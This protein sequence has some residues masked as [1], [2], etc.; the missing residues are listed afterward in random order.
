MGK[1]QKGDLQVKKPVYEIHT[2]DQQEM[3]EANRQADSRLMDQQ[4]FLDQQDQERRTI[5]AEHQKLNIA[6][7]DHL[8]LSVNENL[9]PKF[10]KNSK[11]KKQGQQDN[12]EKLKT[13]PLEQ[14]HKL[15]IAQEIRP[16][17][18]EEVLLRREIFNDKAKKLH[19]E[20][21]SKLE[22]TIPTDRDHLVELRTNMMEE[23]A[24]YDKNNVKHGDYR[25]KEEVPQE[26]RDHYD[27]LMEYY[28][29]HDDSIEEYHSEGQVPVELPLNEYHVS[30]DGVDSIYEMQGRG[31]NNCFC[32]SGSAML[33][34]F[35]RNRN[36]EENPTRRFN[37]ND[38]RA[39]RP[40]IKKYDPAGK[41]IMN[42]AQRKDYIKEVDRYTGANKS[43]VGNVFD[44][45]DF[46]LDNLQGQNA[47]LNKMYFQMPPMKKGNKE[48]NLLRSN[49][50]KAVFMDKISEVLATGNV[51]SFLEVD[52]NYGHYLTITGLDGDKIQYL[53][54]GKGANA[55]KTQYKSVDEFLRRLDSAGNPIEIAWLSDMKSPEEL[56]KEYS[57]L[58][59]DAEKGY[60]L[61]QENAD[62]IQNVS[63]TKGIAV[64]KEM[65]DMG[66]GMDGIT[67]VAY[68]PNP[69]AE[70]ENESIEEALSGTHVVQKA[71]NKTENQVEQKPVEKEAEQKQVE[72]KNVQQPEEEQV[73]EKVEEQAKQRQVEHKQVEKEQ[74]EEQADQKTERKQ[75]EKKAVVID[76][77]KEREMNAVKEQLSG[78]HKDKNK[79]QKKAEKKLISN[80]EKKNK[81][82]EAFG[83]GFSLDK[84]NVTAADSEYMRRVKTALAEYLKIRREIFEKHGFE[85]DEASA[86]NISNY[87]KFI[88]KETAG[89][90]KLIHNKGMKKGIRGLNDSEREVLGN[91]FDIV[92]GAVDDYKFHHNKHLAFGRGRARYRQISRIKEQL[93]MDNARFYLSSGRRNIVNSLDK[94]Y[95]GN[96]T[97]RKALMPTWHKAF[98]LSSENDVDNQIYR[99]KRRRQKAEGTLPPWYKRAM[100]WTG[101]ATIN[102]I[103]RL[104][105]MYQG[106]GGLVDRSL[107][108]ATMLAANS[109]TFAGKIV[110]APLKL[111]SGVFNGASKYI[112]RSKKRWEVDYSLK[113]GWK[114]VDD[115]RR[116]FRKYLK[117]A[118]IL[119]AAVTETITRGIPYIFGHHFKSGVYKRTRKWSKAIY[120]DVKDVMKGIG[121]KNYGAEDRAD[122]DYEMAGGITADK[123]GNVVEHGMLNYSDDEYESETETAEEST[124]KKINQKK[125]EKQEE[126]QDQVKAKQQKSENRQKDSSSNKKAEAAQG[127]KKKQVSSADQK[128]DLNQAFENQQIDGYLNE[129]VQ[130][131]YD[132]EKKKVSAADQMLNLKKTEEDV[133]DISILLSNMKLGK[134]EIEE[135]EVKQA[136]LEAKQ[137]RKLSHL[138]LNDQKLTG[139]SEEMEKVKTTLEELELALT[140]EQ[141]HA[142]TDKNVD[143]LQVCYGRAIDACQVYCDTKHPKTDTGKRRKAKVQATLARLLS[144]S[145]MIEL[146]RMIIKRDGSEAKNV[147]N[148]LQLLSLTAVQDLAD[149][150]VVKSRKEK[151]QNEIDTINENIRDLKADI[152]IN[153]DAYMPIILPKKAAYE[154]E[155]SD[156]EKMKA[157]YD[158]LYAYKRDVEDIGYWKLT[159]G[160]DKEL[161]DAH[162]LLKEKEAE[163]DKAKKA[164]EEAASELRKL[165]EEKEALEKSVESKKTEYD[166][167]DKELKQRKDVE[168]AAAAQEKQENVKQLENKI[169]ELP[170][171]L[172][173]LTRMISN[174]TMPTS[175]IKN[176]NKV[177]SSERKALSDLLLVRETLNGFKVGTAHSKM[178]RIADKYVRLIQDEFGNAQIQYGTV[179]VPIAFNAAYTVDMIATDVMH[180]R[181]IYGDHAVYDVI[182]DLKTDLSGMTRGDLIRT[183]DFA[184]QIIFEITG[185]PKTLLN[186]F[187]ASELKSFALTSLET[188]N[189]KKTLESFKKNLLKTANTKN[190][191]KKGKNI[192][193]VLNQELQNV[194][195][196]ETEGIELN[197]DQREDQSNWDERERKVRDLVADM[198]FSKDTWVA[199]NLVKDPAERMRQML[200]DHAEAVAL[201]IAD[202]FRNKEK[203]PNGLIETIL[204]KLPL[205][206]M[207]QE[208]VKRFR[209][210]IAS[211]LD[212]IKTFMTDM[213]DEMEEGFMKN[214]A[215]SAIENSNMALLSPPV[216][217]PHIKDALKNLNKDGMDKLTDL[218]KRIDDAVK[219]SMEGVQES[220]EKCIGDIFEV[221]E[222]EEEQKEKEEKEKKAKNEVPEL[223]L[224]DLA[225]LLDG[226]TDEEFEQSIANEPPMKQAGKR[227]TRQENLKVYR[228]E[229][230]R[231]EKLEAERAAAKAKEEADNREKAQII[232][233]QKSIETL[234][235]ET[236]VIK[237]EVESMKLYTASVSSQLMD[238]PEQ[239]RKKQTEAVEST[240]IEIMAKEN[241]IKLNESELVSRKNV[242]AAYEKKKRMEAIQ[243]RIDDRA[244]A[245]KKLED[246]RKEKSDEY[247]RRFLN[248][249][250]DDLSI[251]AKHDKSSLK[252]AIDKIDEDLENMKKKSSKELEKILED[253]LKGGKKG[254]S[255]FIKNVFLT[256]FK[257]V[258]KLDKRSMVASAIKNS[259]ALPLMSEEERKKLTDG[260]ILEYMSSMIG[261][262]FKGA[263][264]L[265]QKML[266]GLPIASL[267]K[268]LR[269][270]V[271]DTQDSL[272]SIPDEVVKAHMD[273][274]K[275]RSAGKITKIE[276][277]KSLGAASVGQA[278]LCKVY[279]PD[280]TEGKNVVIKL[281][282]PDVR[283]RMMREKA[284][285][286]EAA[287]MTDEDGMLASEVAEKRKNNVV[288]G[289]EATYMGNLQRIEEELD[290]TI[291]AKN[292]MEGQVYDNPVYDK[293]AKKYKENISNS[294]KLSDL[295]EATSDT[296]VMEIAG[297][298]TVKRYMSDVNQRITD[299]LW[300][301]CEKVDEVD[302]HGQKTGKQ[303]LKRDEKDGS[304]VFRELNP[305]EKIALAPIIEEVSELLKDQE[306]R[307]KALSQV[308]EKW[309]TEGVFQKGY[310]HG[311]LHAGNIMIS[312][313]GVTVIDFGNATI[314]NKDQQKHI[315]RMMVAATQGDVERFRHGFHMLLENTPE[316]VYQEKRDELTL[317]FKEIMSI[318]DESSAAERI[319]VALV[320]AQE[321]G[322]EL[323]PTI[324]NFSSCQM[325]LQNTLNDMN[326]SLKATRANL[327][328][329]MKQNKYLPEQKM[330]D[331]VASLI[332][333][334]KP[335]SV[336]EQKTNVR[337]A[338]TSRGEIDE[339]AFREMLRDKT[340][341]DELREAN[342]LNHS[343]IN[344]LIRKDAKKFND[345]LSGKI[346]VT[347][348]FDEMKMD[349]YFPNLYEAQNM[350]KDPKQASFYSSI[351]NKATQMFYAD[352]AVKE[353]LKDMY[354][355]AT[356]FEEFVELIK[357][358]DKMH[359]N[360]TLYQEPSETEKRLDAF[361]KAQDNKKTTPQQLKQL[362]DAVWESYRAEKEKSN[363]AEA[364]KQQYFKTLKDKYFPHK[365]G[366]EDFIIMQKKYTGS[367]LDIL[368]RTIDS[369]A[370]NKTNG[371]QLKKV[372]EELF[373]LH[374]KAMENEESF[375]ANEAALNAKFDEMLNILWEA[376]TNAI[377]ELGE[378]AKDPIEISKRDP[379]N[380]LEI[381]GGIMGDKK[382][383]VMFSLDASVTTKMIWELAT[384]KVKHFFNANEDE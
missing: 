77:K 316:E 192:N 196:K 130:A 374:K 92:S 330:N 297:T 180:N 60:S 89:E 367:Q 52:G 237:N 62:S 55:Q 102:N 259:N 260:Q 308:V 45:G 215:K 49:N 158:K 105:M 245:F 91:A 310:Y 348:P 298:K 26:V 185:V 81:D 4:L 307:Q 195:H 181:K 132:M 25:W 47:M 125:E 152:V 39:Y 317:I 356:S 219:D 3:K 384:D 238:M 256:Y 359:E 378:N 266:Q 191:F 246:E 85:N 11:E 334:N 2:D 320:R 324:A 177:T 134:Y 265:F 140:T 311:D 344:E 351:K 87:N 154:M 194:G 70:A 57:N 290:L 34:Q 214:M 182:S 42:E 83:V 207:G 222:D 170:E 211:C 273:G 98:K 71:A 150:M 233:I 357:S 165:K 270:A 106:I 284:V 99:N 322:L 163:R 108:F 206:V 118:C 377:R 295:V 46:F 21:L 349:D 33:N 75:A 333:T 82:Y 76:E 382:Y 32:C 255:L 110:K 217:V 285:M 5:D 368:R 136:K 197:L 54:S 146:G 135:K 121:F 332:E 268:G 321:I 242:V 376:Q 137:G 66:P 175:I 362:E 235:K 369:A 258:D 281:L 19:E 241:R 160:G 112:F 366:K 113:K 78:S 247:N 264:P 187:T 346:K 213:V 271:E 343:S 336:W 275:E 267:P 61:K 29:I 302:K 159:F 231:I 300:D 315:I 63:Q 189:D 23:Y 16:M 312:D 226:M 227:K 156:Y 167:V 169:S 9:P 209:E 202:Q 292:C 331:P 79:E 263:G 379:D 94:K 193:T 383:D 276:V 203:N 15:P 59:Y 335:L 339:A 18:R 7:R 153:A 138:M 174:G 142:L 327:E 253:S 104:I 65:G 342:G 131:A 186:N 126:K 147:T 74:I 141:K 179:K 51:V 145:E 212:E 361:Y 279:G 224:E 166:N 168:K 372:A 251:V 375:I 20:A 272:A 354:G 347:E 240:K 143:A 122:A 200:I 188:K 107:G 296:C 363:E 43:A 31:T 232:E 93:T 345:L 119:P 225:V 371:E 210:E 223:K 67:Q 37:Q 41:R 171:E 236:D 252:N 318:G 341:R 58:N 370:K 380:F 287:R 304:F 157:D 6:K 314:L 248:E 244:A 183:R 234:K 274:I 261:G 139:D 283:N 95:A 329:L 218:D 90:T 360:K 257:S 1:K 286:L 116:I 162:E 365:K 269:K 68:I 80:Y 13:V 35:I 117:G 230:A 358:K 127:T 22:K 184:T 111:L 86:E 38:M 123:Y 201:I 10:I 12:A 103:R 173:V 328:N 291:E 96:E 282:R 69:L 280:M 306:Q 319:A 27:W 355:K 199:D 24:F 53:D 17:T 208:D 364:Y 64:R 28:K 120:E 88:G 144:E 151:I 340:K 176:K 164:Y 338:L 337:T 229:K 149:K 129:E 97:Y 8:R 161:D 326:K 277:N 190:E 50:M 323:P 381:M 128:V 221:E 325:R 178:I 205:F 228:E 352:D 243:K 148:G 250:D 216:L 114:S 262:M 305:D 299:L 133:R 303:V 73:D 350:E 309:V 293:D 101:T 84:V 220:F 373:D 36:K 288:G 124:S 289:M 204:D 14:I 301:Y 239:E 30:V 109:L 353:T 172:Q 72:Q 100:E 155:Q 313:T 294:M 198:I 278:F 115:G 44:M 254:Q 249:K 48:K 40:Q 56:T